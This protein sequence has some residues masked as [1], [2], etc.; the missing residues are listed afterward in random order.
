MGLFTNHNLVSRLQGRSAA[1]M[2]NAGN[3]KAIHHCEDKFLMEVARNQKSL[4]FIWDGC[5]IIL[6]AEHSDDLYLVICHAHRP[7]GAGQTEF[8]EDLSVLADKAFAFYKA[9]LIEKEIADLKAKLSEKMKA[10]DKIIDGK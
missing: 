8:N 6:C 3:T 1:S 7:I 2:V 10:Y 5:E 4:S 9:S